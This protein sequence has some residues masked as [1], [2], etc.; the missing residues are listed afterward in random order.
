MLIGGGERPS[1]VMDRVAELAGGRS[2]RVLI[3]TLASSRPAEAADQIRG[4]L[5]TAGVGQVA[6]LDFDH[7]TA[8]DWETL[9]RVNQ[10]TGI[11]FAGGDQS[12]LASVLRDTQ[13]LERIA[14]LYERGGVVAGTSAGATAVG[15]LMVTG[16]VDANQDPDRAV[17]SIRTGRVATEAGLGLMPDVIVDQHFIRRR[18]HNRLLSA[19]LENPKLLAIGIDESTAIVVGPASEFEVLGE[20]M[21][22]VY[23]LSWA[24]G[25]ET[26]RNG[27]LAANGISLHLLRS[28]QVFDLQGRGV[29][30]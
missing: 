5:E 1:Y 26:D 22:A 30:P 17:R 11:F 13:L 29:A 12:R 9:E 23:D 14:E 2:G 21:V 10:A 28:G 16:S 27:N 4:E 25:V 24:S 3:V 19:A 20:N 6:V 7:E 15:S 18:R 8:D